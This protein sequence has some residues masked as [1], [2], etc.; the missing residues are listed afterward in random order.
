M[1][2]KKWVLETG[3]SGQLIFKAYTSQS[4]DS[5][6]LLYGITLGMAKRMACHSGLAGA[7]GCNWEGRD[8]CLF[9]RTY[10]MYT[11]LH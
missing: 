3:N 7:Q 11:V 4:M 9:C 10:T 8:H 2:K 1:Q 5:S 6:T